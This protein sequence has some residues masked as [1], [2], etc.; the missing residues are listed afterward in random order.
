MYLHNDTTHLSGSFLVSGD[1]LLYEIPD[2]YLSASTGHDDPSRT[3]T[4]SDFHCGT[5]ASPTIAARW[6]V[7]R[8]QRCDVLQP[9]SR[10]PDVNGDGRSPGTGTRDDSSAAG[11]PFLFFFNYFFWRPGPTSVSHGR[12]YRSR[13]GGGTEGHAVVR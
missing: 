8:R 3:K 2:Q 7:R 4:D 10:P 9:N 11:V 13:A 1:G 6:S 12:R 5:V